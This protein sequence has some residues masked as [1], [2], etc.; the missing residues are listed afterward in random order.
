MWVIHVDFMRWPLAIAPFK[1]LSFLFWNNMWRATVCISCQLLSAQVVIEAMP[2]KRKKRWYQ[3][4]CHSQQNL[5]FVDYTSSILKFSYACA[6]MGKFLRHVVH[7][8]W[9]VEVFFLSLFF[10]RSLVLLCC[11]SSDFVSCN[12][13][14]HSPLITSLV[15]SP[16][17]QPLL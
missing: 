15:F 7:D 8:N 4:M 5:Q 9:T 13:F 10:K 6:V 14:F 12:Y 11:Y 16:H 17:I 1:R 2:Q 3:G